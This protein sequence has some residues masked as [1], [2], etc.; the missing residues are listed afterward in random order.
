MTVLG[1]LPTWWAMVRHVPSDEYLPTTY[2]EATSFARP[3]EHWLLHLRDGGRLTVLTH[4]C[5][6]EGDTAVFSLALA[7]DD[8]QVVVDL[9][10]IPLSVLADGFTPEAVTDRFPV[11]RASSATFSVPPAVWGQVLTDGTEIEVLAF[12]YSNYDDPRVFDLLLE[13]GSPP[14]FLVDTLRVPL[15]NIPVDDWSWDNGAPDLL[16]GVGGRR[17]AWRAAVGPALLA[18]LATGGALLVGPSSAPGVALVAVGAM[19]ATLAIAMSA[20]WW[21]AAGVGYTLHGRTLDVRGRRGAPRR[22]DLSGWTMLRL[23]EPFGWS[24]LRRAWLRLDLGA[25][26]SGLPRVQVSRVDADGRVEHGPPLPGAPVFGARGRVAW[27]RRLQDVLPDHYVDID[28]SADAAPRLRGE[29][30]GRSP[31]TAPARR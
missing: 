29:G 11:P 25:P 9:P 19:S 16:D 22:V 12:G 28:V 13:D 7:G 5:R 14:R 17:H 1:R 4:G 24:D 30:P 10:R 15:A 20:A 27:I 2:D 18:L 31:S 6:L 23:T 21:W 26:A 8:G 3:P